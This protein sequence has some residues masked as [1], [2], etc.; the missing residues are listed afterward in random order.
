AAEPGRLGP[1]DRHSPRAHAGPPSG[2]Q[3]IVYIRCLGVDRPVRPSRSADDLKRVSRKWLTTT[4]MSP[5]IEITWLPSVV[6]TG[7]GKKELQSRRGQA[8]VARRFQSLATQAWLS[9]LLRHSL[10]EN[11]DGHQA[12]RNGRGLSGDPRRD[13]ISDEGRA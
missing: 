8:S 12:G 10:T 4:P 11:E 9:L 5:G 6:P 7:H 3:D 2:V 13:R 1:G